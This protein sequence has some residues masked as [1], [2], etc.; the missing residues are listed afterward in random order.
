MALRLLAARQ[1]VADREDLAEAG[2]RPVRMTQGDDHR[3]QL[4]QIGI[5]Q[6]Q[7]GASGLDRD[8]DDGEVRLRVARAVGRVLRHRLGPEDQQDVDAVVLA[9]RRVDLVER[10]RVARRQL[11]VVA[12]AQRVDDPIERIVRPQLHDHQTDLRHP[13][14]PIVGAGNV[15]GRGADRY[16]AGRSIGGRD[17]TI[18]LGSRPERAYGRK[19][20]DRRS[21]S[22]RRSG[23]KGRSPPL[24]PAAG[25][26]S[27]L[28]GRRARHALRAWAPAFAGERLGRIDTQ[29]IAETSSP[30]RGRGT[31]RRMVEGED[32]D[33][34]SRE[35]R[36][37]PPP[38]PSA[39][40]PPGGGG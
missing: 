39:P 7:T 16:G 9:K 1:A 23:S 10:N 30:A 17:R 27:F 37:P 12:P 18:G 35:R 22:N 24:S 13:A 34:V 28:F 11:D 3:R 21:R 38:S 31:I 33:I 36:R 15:R 14:P 8:G 26:A 29:V 40:P 4:L 20:L 6:H 5:E 25:S 32:G 19:G 2:T